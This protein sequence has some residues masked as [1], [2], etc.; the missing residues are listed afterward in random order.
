MVFF[1]LTTGLFLIWFLFRT[2]RKRSRLR[3]R[4][5]RWTLEES[6]AILAGQPMYKGSR[7]PR[8]TSR[9]V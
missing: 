6:T 2:I 1:A 3:R 9:R 7:W 8:D 5:E 4:M